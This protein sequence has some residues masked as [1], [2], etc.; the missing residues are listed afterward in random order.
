MC[1]DEFTEFDISG[2]GV[3][4]P[5]AAAEDVVFA[6]VEYVGEWVLVGGGVVGGI[7]AHGGDVGF[8]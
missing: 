3:G 4:A 5:A 1:C 6:G 2:V 7:L 8:G